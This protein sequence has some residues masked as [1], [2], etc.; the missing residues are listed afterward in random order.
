MRWDLMGSDEIESV[1]EEWGFCDSNG[2]PVEQN[3]VAFYQS[4][5][6]LAGQVTVM[7]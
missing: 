6:A 4:D 5:D 1:A 7:T 2:F 3:N